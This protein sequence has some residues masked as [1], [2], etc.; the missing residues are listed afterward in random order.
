MVVSLMSGQSL[1]ISDLIAA[2]EFPYNQIYAYLILF[3]VAKLMFFC[4]M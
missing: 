4:I 3:I 2:W 1:A